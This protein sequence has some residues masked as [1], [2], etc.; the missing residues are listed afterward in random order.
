MVRERAQLLLCGT[1][2]IAMPFEHKLRGG[3]F[4]QE[5]AAV[6][7]V[8]R[9][10]EMWRGD[11]R[12][13]HT[14]CRLFRLAVPYEFAHGSVF[15]LGSSNRTGRFPASAFYGASVV[16]GTAYLFFRAAPPSCVCFCGLQPPPGPRDAGCPERGKS[17]CSN[18]GPVSDVE[19]TIWH[20]GALGITAPQ[21]RT[22]RSLFSP[23]CRRTAL[24]SMIS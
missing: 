4:W 7:H 1:D 21:R 16:K 23:H 19:R 20:H 17:S 11:F 24:L 15:T 5:S 6:I 13:E 3:F 12:R 22:A 10:A 9:R 8:M 14:R 2:F 18:G